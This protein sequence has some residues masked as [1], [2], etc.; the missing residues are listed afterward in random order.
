[1]LGFNDQVI[2]GVF[3]SINTCNIP[4]KG[5]M[6]L[7]KLEKSSGHVCPVLFVGFDNSSHFQEHFPEI[8]KMFMTLTYFIQELCP[9][10]STP[11]EPS[12][13][14]INIEEIFDHVQNTIQRLTTNI[15]KISDFKIH[16]QRFIQDIEDLNKSI[17]GDLV[18]LLAKHGKTH[19]S[20]QLSQSS[21][22]TIYTCE[23]CHKEVFTNKKHLARHLKSCSP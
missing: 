19:S 21:K 18:S 2:A 5:C 17:M 8:I 13:S 14:N 1:M 10:T 11:S 16:T 6:K 22:K 7:E 15:G 9:P 20:S 23:K 4:G 3:I 12:L